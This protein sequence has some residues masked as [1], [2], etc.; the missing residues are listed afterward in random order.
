MLG[1]SMSKPLS[2]PSDL[3]DEQ[4]RRAEYEQ[5]GREMSSHLDE[6]GPFVRG[7]TLFAVGHHTENRWVWFDFLTVTLDDIMRECAIPG[8]QREERR[9][10]YRRYANDFLRHHTGPEKTLPLLRD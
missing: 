1:V 9:L 10:R 8:E 3:L 5:M 4:T 6:H 2:P 7:D